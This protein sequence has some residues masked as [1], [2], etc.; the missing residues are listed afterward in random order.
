MGNA[1]IQGSL[2]NSS[3]HDWCELQE[4][5]QRPL[6]ESIYD[7]INLSKGTNFLDAGCG[8]GGACLLAKQRGAKITGIEAAPDM[9]KCAQEQVP[10]GKFTLGDIQHLPYESNC[11][12]VVLSSSSLQYSEDR[13]ETLQEFKRV[14]KN[15]GLIVVSLW[16]EPQKVD[17]RIIFEAV[18]S[19]FKI[20]PKGKGPFELSGSGVLEDLIKSVGLDILVSKDV[21][22]PFNYKN[23]DIFWRVNKATGP[24]QM[25]LKTISEAKLKA[26]LREVVRPHLMNDGSIYIDNYFKYVVSKKSEKQKKYTS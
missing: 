15:D 5:L 14:A 18:K 4:P 23:F 9:L 19:L 17:Y 25:A 2:W 7:T 3:A 22:C 16:S 6:W 8:G 12:D 21:H 1:K 11:F 24:L 20:A 10:D 26:K 13:I